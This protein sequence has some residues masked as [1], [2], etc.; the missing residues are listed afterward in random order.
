MLPSLDFL[1]SRAY[2]RLRF[3][4]SNLQFFLNLRWC[5]GVA[6]KFVSDIN[7][8]RER[9]SKLWRQVHSEGSEEELARA[10]GV[11]WDAIGIMSNQLLQCFDKVKQRTGFMDE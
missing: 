5:F 10:L 1:D 6:Q 7:A 2:R 8:E 4:Q 3:Y 9:I 11:W